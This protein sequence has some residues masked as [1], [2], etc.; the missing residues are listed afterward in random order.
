MSLRAA[1][2]RSLPV[3]ADLHH[4]GRREPRSDGPLL[5]ATWPWRLRPRPR[6]NIRPLR[7]ATG[8]AGVAPA[9]RHFQQLEQ[10]SA[11]I[12]NAPRIAR[13]LTIFL[14]SILPN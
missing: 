2:G 14:L 13:T 10:S 9:T 12:T 8:L 4:L 6:A 1:R 11:K 3:F 5:Q 7:A